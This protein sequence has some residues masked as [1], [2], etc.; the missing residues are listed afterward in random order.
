M[1]WRLT[2]SQPK[3]Q[4]LGVVLGTC[5]RGCVTCGASLS[6]STSAARLRIAKHHENRQ[7]AVGRAVLAFDRS[8]RGI[9]GALRPLDFVSQVRSPC[10]P[11]QRE[12]CAIA[13]VP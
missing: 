11:V 9:R 8:A 1:G 5:T 10:N 13:G 7:Q 4:L 3:V 2:T 6:V 12:R